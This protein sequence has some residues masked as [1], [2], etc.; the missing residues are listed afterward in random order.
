MNKRE[1]IEYLDDW[2][3]IGFDYQLKSNHFKVE[4]YK[5]D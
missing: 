3:T 4:I 2:L 5:E 1:I